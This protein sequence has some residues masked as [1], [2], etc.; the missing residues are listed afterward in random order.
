ME[1]DLFR[2]ACDDIKLNLWILSPV[3]LVRIIGWFS[4]S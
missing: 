3:A 1:K 2:E 4:M